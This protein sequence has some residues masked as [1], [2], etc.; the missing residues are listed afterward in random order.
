MCI[1]FRRDAEKEK[2]HA[3]EQQLIFLNFHGYA[4][5][6]KNYMPINV[7]LHLGFMYW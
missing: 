6:S 7:E 5:L 3:E 2:S 4:H 1:H